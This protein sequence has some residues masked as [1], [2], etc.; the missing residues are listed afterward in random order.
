MTVRLSSKHSSV[1]LSVLVLLA[2]WWAV[3]GV[4]LPQR[5]RLAAVRA[6][7]RRELGE[8]QAV[9]TF[10][11]GHP[12]VEAYLAELN[13]RRLYVGKMLPDRVGLEDYRTRLETVARQSGATLIRIDSTAPV[14]RGGYQETRLEVTV[15]GSVVSLL[16]FIKQLEEDSRFTVIN[17][18]FLRFDQR[19]GN[20]NL[21]IR[22]YSAGK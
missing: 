4:F 9:E 11:L 17:S 22:I 20:C 16:S 15:E 3:V 6:E 13:Q 18:A 19:A 8:A 1:F 7:Y 5:E 14:D 21:K 10:A 2:G 12:D